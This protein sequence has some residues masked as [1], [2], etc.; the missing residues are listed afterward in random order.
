MLLCMAWLEWGESERDST[1]YEVLRTERE[2]GGG[3]RQVRMSP[4]PHPIQPSRGQPIAPAE[5]LTR[6]L[7]LALHTHANGDGWA[8]VTKYLLG[9]TTHLPAAC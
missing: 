1:S 8:A 3:E 2:R 4:P 9:Q 6:R 7:L 5:A